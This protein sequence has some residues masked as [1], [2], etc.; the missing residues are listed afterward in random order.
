MALPPRPDLGRFKMTVGFMLTPTRFL[1]ACHERSAATTSRCIRSTGRWIVVTADPAAVKEVFTGD[2]NLLHAG[3]GNVV[4][5]AD[6]R[7]AARCCC[8]TAPSTCASGG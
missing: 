4:L 6:P 3:E 5:A 7:L 1:D 2:P 8:S